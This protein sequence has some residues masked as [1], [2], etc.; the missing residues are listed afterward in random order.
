MNRTRDAIETQYTAFCAEIGLKLDPLC[1]NSGKAYEAG[2]ALGI[3]FNTE[4]LT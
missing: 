4:S 2:T 1:P 3:R